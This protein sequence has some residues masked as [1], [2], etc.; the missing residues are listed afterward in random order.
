MSP[1]LGYY[2]Q[3][4][5]TGYIAVIELGSDEIVDALSF[6]R[7][8]S[9]AIFRHRFQLTDDVQARLGLL[10]SVF[11]LDTI[12]ISN[13]IHGSAGLSA[14]FLILYLTGLYRRL[15]KGKAAVSLLHKGVRLRDHFRNFVPTMSALRDVQH[16]TG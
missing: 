11:W 9:G 1:T 15:A 4:H 12:S 16:T 3:G 7:T 10:N 2:Y 14:L 8:P 6:Q 5:L 13:P